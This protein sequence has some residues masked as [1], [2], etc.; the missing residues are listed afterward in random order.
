MIAQH[1][2]FL[3]R[4]TDTIKMEIE[5]YASY[6]HESAEAEALALRL[7]QEASENGRELLLSV[8]AGWYVM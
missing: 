2:D 3:N 5:K 4:N 6:S 1:S 7:F 8:A